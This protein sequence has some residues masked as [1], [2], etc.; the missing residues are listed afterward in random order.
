[1]S[2]LGNRLGRFEEMVRLR[3]SAALEI[4]LRQARDEDLE[5]IAKMGPGGEPTHEERAALDRVIDRMKKS[6]RREP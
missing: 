6:L 2:R 5:L 3:V 1:M 4:A